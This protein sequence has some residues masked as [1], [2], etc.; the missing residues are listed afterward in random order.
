VT[1][2][3]CLACGTQFPEGL[4]LPVSCPICSDERQFVP[5]GGQRF[6]SLRELRA[7]CQNVIRQV[8]DNLHEIFTRPSFAIGQR[9]YLVQTPKGNLLWDCVALVDPSTVSA[10][11]ALGGV[12]AIAI[13]HPHYYTTMVEWSREFGNIPIYLHAADR[14]WVQRPDPVIE[15]WDGETRLLLP[16]LTMIRC[17]GHF[18]GG[19][20]LHW[21][22]GADGHG[23]LLCGDVIQVAPDRRWVSFMYSYPNFIPLNA[24][25]VERIVHAVAPYRFDHIY[26]AFGHVIEA[27]GAEALKRSAQRYLR[28]IR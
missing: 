14:Q 4:T 19:C 15:F 21:A 22:N 2:N 1:S 6:T 3:I 28:A 9:A 20:V 8:D 5:P 17:G 11:W 26:G 23:A 10:L 13:S 18:S 27:E 12:S 7:N 16:D 25:A 24:E